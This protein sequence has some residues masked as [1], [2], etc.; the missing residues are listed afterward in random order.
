MDQFQ[1]F[2]EEFSLCLLPLWLYL[3][4]H[5]DK[6]HSK[7]NSEIEV[8]RVP[9]RNIISRNYYSVFSALWGKILSV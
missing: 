7:L 2:G 9:H 6:A 5:P 1:I 3:L 4:E 8:Q